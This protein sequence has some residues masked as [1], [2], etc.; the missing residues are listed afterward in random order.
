MILFQR[1][2]ILSIT[3]WDDTRTKEMT[4]FLYS[5]PKYWRYRSAMREAR[6]REAKDTLEN[7][8]D[9]EYV[10]VKAV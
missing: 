7:R 3:Y 1:W 9:C 8:F 2:Q 10:V 6:R 4:R 5:Y